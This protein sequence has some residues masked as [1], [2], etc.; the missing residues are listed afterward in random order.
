LGLA[1]ISV[2][3]ASG[4][5]NRVP[6]VGA[7]AITGLGHDAP[8]APAVALA[9][10]QDPH[11]RRP[12]ETRVGIRLDVFTANGSPLLRAGPALVFAAEPAQIVLAA[13]R[14]EEHGQQPDSSF[15]IQETRLRKT[16]VEKAIKIREAIADRE[17]RRGLAAAPRGES[18]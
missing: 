7:D 8:A 10:V 12:R 1:G 18:R 17:P 15:P 3:V 11:A 6:D 16:R 2:D 9:P 14:E 13:C 4:I 5:A